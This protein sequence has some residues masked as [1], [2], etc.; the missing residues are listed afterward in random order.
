MNLGISTQLIWVEIKLLEQL[1]LPLYKVHILCHPV[2]IS[3]HYVLHISTH[4]CLSLGHKTSSVF[5]HFS[6]SFSAVTN[7]DSSKARD[8][9]FHSGQLAHSDMNGG[10]RAVAPGYLLE[11]SARGSLRPALL[12]P[13]CIV[14]RNHHFSLSEEQA[15]PLSQ[16]VGEERR[17]RRECEV[18]EC[19]C[20]PVGLDLFRHHEKARTEMHKRGKHKW[21]TQNYLYIAK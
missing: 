1:H 3:T 10:F 15:S 19:I 13:A 16:K 20:N 5:P 14:S 9:D 6:S 8:R 7:I 11:P 18:R 17:E 2:C 4:G 12:D 21:R